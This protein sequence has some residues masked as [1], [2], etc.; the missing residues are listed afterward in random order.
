MFLIV[1]GQWSFG[2]RTKSHQLDQLIVGFGLVMGFLDLL[3]S[4]SLHHFTPTLT[5]TP[6]SLTFTEKD[7]LLCN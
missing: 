1:F 6:I 3:M 7:A 4:P 5:H 2:Y